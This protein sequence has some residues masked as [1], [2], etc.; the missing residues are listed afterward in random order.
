MAQGE[1]VEEAFKAATTWAVAEYGR[2]GYTGTLAEK[3]QFRQVIA[4]E[5]SGVWITDPRFREWMDNAM[6]DEDYYDKWG[7][8]FAVDL[9]PVSTTEPR[10]KR[11]HRW[12][13]FGWAS[14]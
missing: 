3:G 10:A 12:I 4:P 7:P 6:E 2:Q 8:A 14:S 9:G 1:T 13:F 11:I 5:L